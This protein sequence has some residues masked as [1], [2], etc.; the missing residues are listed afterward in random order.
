MGNG[1]C[2]HCGRSIS[3]IQID[4]H[5]FL[6]LENPD[7]H[8]G[9]LLQI[10][11]QSVVIGGVGYFPSIGGFDIDRS[12]G[13]PSSRTL[14]RRF[15]GSWDAVRLCYAPTMPSIMER[16]FIAAADWQPQAADELRALQARHGGR[17]PRVREARHEYEVLLYFHYVAQ[18]GTKKFC[19]EHGLNYV[20][21]QG[22]GSG[23]AEWKVMDKT[24]A[25]GVQELGAARDRSV[26]AGDG[27]PAVPGVRAWL[28]RSGAV[29]QQVVY[30]LV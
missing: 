4:R 16:P 26:Q 27:M 28:D 14:L 13:I 21:N 1:T 7:V 12:A 3:N 6:C 5:K 29:C 20:T 30:M 24:P 9:I 22:R 11:E 2:P 18:Y 23:T 25:P 8:A 17:L 15:G 10:R 19:T